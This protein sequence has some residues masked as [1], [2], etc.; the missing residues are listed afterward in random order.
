MENELGRNAVEEMNIPFDSTKKN[1]N[2]RA[3]DGPNWRRTPLQNG[4]NNQ[5]NFEW[6]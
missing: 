6:L 1:K 4:Q 5:V 2:N 3:I